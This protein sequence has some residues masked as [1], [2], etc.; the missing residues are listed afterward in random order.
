MKAGR[1]KTFAL[2]YHKSGN[3]TRSAIAAGYSS[4]GASSRAASLLKDE[5]VQ[6]ELKRL[7]SSREKKL[8]PETIEPEVKEIKQIGEITHA[9]ILNEIAQIAFMDT[10]DVAKSALNSFHQTKLKALSLMH[11]IHQSEKAER[12]KQ[13]KIEAI[14]MVFDREIK[15]IGM[16]EGGVLRLVNSDIGDAI[17]PAIEAARR[18]LPEIERETLLS[19]FDGEFDHD[20]DSKQD[21]D[22]ACEIVSPAFGVMNKGRFSGAIGVSKLRIKEIWDNYANE[23]ISKL[24]KPTVQ[25]AVDYVKH[26]RLRVEYV[27]PNSDDFF[28]FLVN[29][30]S[31][32]EKEAVKNNIIY[33]IWEYLGLEDGEDLPQYYDAEVQAK[34]ISIFDEKTRHPK[35]FILK[36]WYERETKKEYPKELHEDS[37]THELYDSIGHKGFADTIHRIRN[38]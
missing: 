29:S 8:A 7:A 6:E 4:N 12:K 19:R 3:G 25:N 35:S 22:L 11:E 15:D 5:E 10:S 33:G 20:P 21:H 32:D 24:S 27:S 13:D 30:L 23:I 36:F 9:D 16:E 31:V 18:S 17:K 34:M 28:A 26:R 38:A 2:E 37:R 1:K 14:A